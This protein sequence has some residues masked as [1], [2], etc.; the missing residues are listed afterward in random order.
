MNARHHE[1]K[2]LVLL[3]GTNFRGIPVNEN[4]PLVVNY[5]ETIQRVLDLALDQ[6]NRLFIV[7]VDLHLPSRPECDDYPSEFGTDVISRYFASLNAQIQA[8]LSKKRNEGKR[9]HSC[10]LRFVW[11]KERHEALQDHYHVVLFFNKDTYHTLGDYTQP[12]HNLSTKIVNAWASALGIEYFQANPLVHFP[13]DTPYYILGK[14]AYCFQSD[15][16]LV[17]KRLSY[18]AKVDTKHYGNRSHSFGASRK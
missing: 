6:Y 9:V 8:D 12:G 4:Y 1:N 7:R 16:P 2:N 13:R 15:Y 3:N 14:D 18:F 17:F 5:L 10:T 11:V